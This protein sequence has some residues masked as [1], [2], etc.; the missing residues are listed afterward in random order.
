LNPDWKTRYPDS[1]KDADGKPLPKDAALQ[2][3]KEE[4]REGQA[5]N[6]AQKKAFEFLEKL[7]DLYQKQPN[8][9][10]HLEKLAAEATLQPAV[11]EPFTR[12]GPKGLKVPAQFA[13]VALAL[14]PQQ[15]VPSEPLPGADGVYVISL[16]Q[17]FPSEVQSFE[18]VR[19]R[20]AEDHRRDEAKEAARHAGEAFYSKL[21]NSL[22]QNKSFEDSCEE[23]N[24]TLEKL[25]AFSLTTRALSP[26]LE[27]RV[28]LSLLKD[29]AFTL[30]PG[31][32]SGFMQSRDGG[33]VLHVVSRDPVDEARLKTELP[34][35]IERLREERRREASNEWFRKELS[36]AQIT[37]P[38]APKK[39][40]P[41]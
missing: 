22:A 18:A 4:V 35:F 8:E 28:G 15:P 40:N 31:K 41:N 3:L 5:M 6:S 20:V 11:T 34:A 27:S 33:L 16:K 1:Y 36:L 25:P 30:A 10:N 14:T 9:T 12:D 7:Y 17:R 29:V 39:E 26:E 37:G 23:A 2:K 13:Q 32:T 21:T 19:E 38:L 24:V